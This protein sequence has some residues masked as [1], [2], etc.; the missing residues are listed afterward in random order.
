MEQA[1]RGRSLAAVP[2]QE[3]RRAKQLG[4]SDAQLAHLLGS[5]APVAVEDRDG[6]PW[7]TLPERLPVSPA[8]VLVL[9]GG[10]RPSP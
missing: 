7:F 10:V 3:L 6:M 8:H 4:F 1:L 5:D 9:P 2:D